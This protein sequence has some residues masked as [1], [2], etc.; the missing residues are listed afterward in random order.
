MFLKGYT[1]DV[2]NKNMFFN[3]PAILKMNV[4]RVEMLS[5]HLLILH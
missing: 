2:S 1:V 3:K 5:L 4:K